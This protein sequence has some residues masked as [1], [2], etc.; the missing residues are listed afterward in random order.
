MIRRF[1]VTIALTVAFAPA[2]FAQ[3]PTWVAIASD[4]AGLW[5]VAVG[6]ADREA[7]E[8]TALGQCGMYCKLKFTSQARCVAYAFS[9]TGR[10][11][12]FSAGATRPAVEQDA[13]AECN[14][15]VP[16]NSCRVETARCFE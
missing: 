12:G 6:M 7:A 5:G 3:Q 13:W 11:E 14:A 16:A 8:Q 1:A 15:N 10:A 9:P 2:A 4:G